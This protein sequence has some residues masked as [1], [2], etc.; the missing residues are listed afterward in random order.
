MGVV[1]P[2]KSGRGKLRFNDEAGLLGCILLS[3]TASL[4]YAKASAHLTHEMFLE[5]LFAGV[6]Y[7]IGEAVNKGALRGDEVAR[8]VRKAFCENPNVIETFGDVNAFTVMLVR[9][10]VMPIQLEATIQSIRAEW[11]VDEAEAAKEAGEYSRVASIAT[12]VQAIRGGG[13]RT[14]KAFNSI[15]S[16][17]GKL[18]DDLNERLQTG[19]L[20]GFAT[21]GSRTVN[22]MIGGFKPGRFYVVGARP[23]MGKTTVGVSLL[24]KSAK[25]GHGVLMFSLE[26]TGEEIGA[27][28]MCDTAFDGGTRIEYRDLSPERLLARDRRAADSDFAEIINA[29]ETVSKLPFTIMDKA[30]L[31][32]AEIKTNAAKCAEDMARNGKRLEV[33]LID[34]LNLIRP[35]ERYKGLKAFETEQTSNQLKVLAK[36]LGVAVVCLVQLNRGVEGREDKM[37]MLADLRNSGAIEQ[38]ADVVMFVYRKAYYLER[39]REES[40]EA[41][42]KR[43]DELDGCRNTVELLVAKNRGGP[44]GLL[45]LWCDMGTGTVRDSQ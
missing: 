2:L 9:S 31:S 43:L 44:T 34:H 17:A 25:A 12:E 40:F 36:E 38:D 41:E 37:P 15:G 28:M 27:M 24:R 33:I 26:M 16:V 20:D 42:Q 21:T 8:H 14:E 39:A 35:D 19:V 1:V 4:E 7:E 45:K 5:P 13:F 29:G 30:G 10:A 6:F 3:K 23:S 11:L 18:I 22:D 32:I